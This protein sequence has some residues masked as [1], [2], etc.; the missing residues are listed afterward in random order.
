MVDYLLLIEVII[1]N[2]KMDSLVYVKSV[3]VKSEPL[4]QKYR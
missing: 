2:R 1:S 3:Y 4:F